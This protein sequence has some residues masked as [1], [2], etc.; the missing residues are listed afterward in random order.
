M[1]HFPSCADYRHVSGIVDV[2]FTVEPDGSVGDLEVVQEV[3]AAFGFGK[4]F[5]D[6]FAQWKFEPK[7]VEGKPTAFRAHYH[8]TARYGG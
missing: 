7:L 8:F 2:E 6:A 4:A 1:P 3:P 5:S